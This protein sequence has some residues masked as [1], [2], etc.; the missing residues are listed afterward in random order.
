MTSDV[1]DSSGS[2]NEFQNRTLGGNTGADADSSQNIEKFAELINKK[3][4]ET[5]LQTF[6]PLLLSG[7]GMVL[8]YTLA[9]SGSKSPEKAH[10]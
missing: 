10:T 8:A 9:Q 2:G 3:K 1:A 5:W 7:V 4:H 6:L